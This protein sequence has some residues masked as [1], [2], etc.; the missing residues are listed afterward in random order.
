MPRIILALSFF[1]VLMGC[2][3]TSRIDSQVG[4]STTPPHPSFLSKW[5]NA[6]PTE[7][8]KLSV[9]SNEASILWWKTYSLGLSK[10]ET[11]P[12]EACTSFKTLSE[13][14]EFPL[15]DLALLRAYQTCT[16]DV[17]LAPL[18]PTTTS[19]YAELN[20]DIKMKEAKV[21]ANTKDDI[22]AN[23][24]KAKLE[25]NKKNKEDFLMTA[26]L[27]A[28]KSNMKEET[29]QIQNQLYKNSPRLNPAPTFKDLSNVA[30]DYRFHREF[31]KAID[32][33]KKIIANR[34]ATAEDKFQAL[35]NIRMTYKVAQRRQE[36]INA[37][38]DLVNWSKKQFRDNKKDRKA[39]AHFHDT[40]VLFART[41]WTE[42]QGTQ[43][44]KVLN[45]TH[46]LLRGTYPM[47]EVYFI[48]G[49]MEEEKGHYDKA[50]EY[51]EASYEQPISS[52]GLRDKIAWLK[53]WNY[54]KLEKWTE[55]RKSLEQMKEISKDPSDKA[56]AMFWLARTLKN[57][58]DQAAAD[59]QLNELIKEDPLGYYGMLA[60]RELNQ[61]YPALK[62]DSDNGSGLSI[63]G[64][65]ELD[66]DLRL[67]IEWLIAVSEK[68]FAE[69]AL[70]QATEDLNKAK[71][72]SEST[73]LAMSSG[74]ARAG[75]YLPLFS[76]LGALQPEVKD[77][78]LQDHPDL[79]FPQP[80]GD[81]VAS[82][83]KKSGIPREFIYGI[84]RQ[85]SAFNPEARSGADAFG[86]MQLLPSVAKNLAT[87]NKL[88][89][90]E[91][92]DLYKPEVN[93]PLGAFELKSLMK[94]YDNQYILA[95]AGYNANDSAIR[96]WLKTRFRNDSVEF[97]EEVPY[98][99]TRTYIKLT[100]RNYVFYQRLLSPGVSI[101]FPE[102]LLKLNH[103]TL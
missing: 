78:L 58:K 87:A 41:L 70:N 23:L 91:A 96:G 69:K 30:M 25:T 14:P 19:W 32:T 63:L 53:A 18:P 8:E 93:I 16:K 7:L 98:E 71:V 92:L 102:D 27:L 31:D 57:L 83:A 42:D 34:E 68:S 15:H 33:Y 100:M 73:W 84:I 61:D 59:T 29:E 5:K 22:E 75:L 82:A 67:K 44:M 49:R 45:E 13:T 48:M 12:K 43:A 101:K 80:Y 2:A 1:S 88:E 28:Q 79:L 81:I 9:G 52:A 50:L 76:T 64:I 85:E 51:Y 26:L 77:H 65:N 4:K 6:P 10:I 66:S 47:D 39:L 94:K 99:E 17:K 95:V 55:A 21:T 97:I 3:T 37:S 54:Y 89:Y 60:Y 86:L 74:Y 35:K 103:K 20:A 38:S 11:A 24:D 90:G 40:Q 46:R 36:Y 72:T 56:K 62:I